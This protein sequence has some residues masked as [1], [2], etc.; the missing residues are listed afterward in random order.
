MF[1]RRT[2]FVLAA[3]LVTSLTFVILDLRGGQG[4]FTSFRSAMSGA[5]GGGE[6][7]GSAVFS[8]FLGVRDW[9]GSWGDQR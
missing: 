6:Q 4:P 8:P 9:W 7:V 5:V 1:S 3:L 2:R